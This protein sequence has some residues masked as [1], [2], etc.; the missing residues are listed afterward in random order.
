MEDTAHVA[1]LRPETAQGIF[2]NSGSVETSRLK[3]PFGSRQIGKSFAATRSR[4]ALPFRRRVQQMELEFFVRPVTTM[5]SAL[6][7]ERLRWYRTG[8][9]ADGL[10]VRPRRRELRTY[11]KACCVVEYRFPFGWAS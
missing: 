3:I 9:S 11:A 2:V 7:R 10:R 6:A 8:L 5:C 4:P 1:Y